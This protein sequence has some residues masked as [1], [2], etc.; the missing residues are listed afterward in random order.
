MDMEHRLLEEFRR[1][2][3]ITRYDLSS[4]ATAGSG[5]GGTLEATSNVTVCETG[6]GNCNGVGMLAQLLARA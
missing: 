3:R 6:P 2:A 5:E 4:A 1:A